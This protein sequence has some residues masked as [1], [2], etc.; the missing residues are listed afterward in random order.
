[1][2]SVRDARLHEDDAFI[3]TVYLPLS[4]VFKERSQS[5][6]FYPLAGGVGYG[7]IRVSMLFRSVQLRAPRSMLGWDCGTLEISHEAQGPDLPHS[8]QLHRIKFRT[9]LAKGKMYSSHE[10][11]KW[12][13]HKDEAIRL[14]VVKRYTTPLVVEFRSSS[15][16]LDKTP[17]FS[18][19]WLKNIPDDEEQSIRLPV[20]K[21]NLK[22]A[23]KNCLPEDELGERIGT[24]QFKVTFWRGLGGYHRKYASSDQNMKDVMESLDVANGIINSAHDMGEHGETDSGSDDDEDEPDETKGLSKA[25]L[26]KSE[27]KDGAGSDKQNKTLEKDGKRGLKEEIKEY[28]QH[29][30]ELH[31]RHRG[32]MQWKVSFFII[33]NALEH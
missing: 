14:P 13:T 23:E 16:L 20:F 10:D 22:R 2:V 32:V 33:A 7:R 31:G 9:T 18:V 21:G 28:K 27:D 1:M 30:N 3:G 5:V 12:S 29:K 17:A 24:L 4:E 26:K 25:R 11:G 6:Q 8:L 15:I 19:L